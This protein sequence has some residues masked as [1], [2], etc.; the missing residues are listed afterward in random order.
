MTPSGPRKEEFLQEFI[1]NPGLPSEIR[2]Q[3]Q[4]ETTDE[5]PSIA[6]VQ[7]REVNARELSYRRHYH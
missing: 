4:L 6:L 1:L 3:R 2:T 5:H 7:Y